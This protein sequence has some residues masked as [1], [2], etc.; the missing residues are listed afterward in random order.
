MT[1]STTEHPFGSDHPFARAVDALRAVVRIPT[2]S[3]RDDERIDAAAFERLLTELAERFPRAHALDVTRIEPHALLVRWAGETDADPIVLMAHLDVVPVDGDA[4]WTR[5]PFGG[6]LADAPEG[7]CVWGRGTLD[8]K[9]S[10]VAILTAVE[11]LL[12]SGYTPARDV[13]LSF[14]CNE[15]VSGDA[16]P[17]AVATLRER[18]VTPW[19]VLDEGGA[20]ASGAFPG[21]TAPIGVVG[22]AEKGSTMIELV[23]RGG[24]GHGSTPAANGPAVRIANAVA[25]LDRL[26]LPRRVP[27]PTRELLARLAPHLGGPLHPLVGR[28]VRAESLVASV[29]ARAG[30]ETRAIVQTTL[31]FT[32]LSAADGM[33]VI[34]TTAKAGVNARILPGDTVADIVARI[35]RA[36]DDGVEIDVVEAAEPSAVSPYSTAEV[37]DPA[38]A[39]LES[40]IGEIFPDAVPSPYVMM[41]ATDSRHFTEICARVYRFSPFRMSREQR[42]TIHSVDERITVDTLLEGVGWY[43]SLLQRLG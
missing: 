6:D 27:A 2:I 21:V 31:A 24:G 4:P 11:T 35:R 20:I 41:A 13:W 32:T 17:R 3:Y 28:I 15:E 26:S 19:F 1:S 5:P 18:G 42:A 16:A 8:D 14:G 9:G 12:E 36:I 34:P 30:A 29:L 23:A 43:R 39:L 40:V 10:A 38:F 25:A 37:T 22:V 7:L 33:N